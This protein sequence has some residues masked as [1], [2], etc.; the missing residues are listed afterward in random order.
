MVKEIEKEG[1][2][3]NNKK[4]IE[5]LSNALEGWT[6]RHPNPSGLIG[7]G[8]KPPS[9]PSPSPPPPP[10]TKRPTSTPPCEDTPQRAS[11][12]SQ[13]PPLAATNPAATTSPPPPTSLLLPRPPLAPLPPLPHAAVPCLSDAHSFLRCHR[14]WPTFG[15]RG[16]PRPVPGVDDA[17]QRC[18]GHHQHR[19]CPHQIHEI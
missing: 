8:A 15:T 17:G 19:A 1:K 3:N 7:A 11:S 18:H 13:P 6:R 10:P 12:P 9:P 14:R 4:C 5:W 2:D 16:P